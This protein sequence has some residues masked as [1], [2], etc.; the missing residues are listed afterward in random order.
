M[1][2]H[3]LVYCLLFQL[4]KAHEKRLLF[5]HP[6]EQIPA[7]SRHAALDGN[8]I[9]QLKNTS[10]ALDVYRTIAGS[11]APDELGKDSPNDRPKKGF[12]ARC[13][14]SDYYEKEAFSALQRATSVDCKQEI[15]DVVCSQKEGKLFTGKELPNYCTLRS[16]HILYYSGILLYIDLQLSCICT[17]KPVFKEHLNIPYYGSIWSLH[18]I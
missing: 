6:L 11:H 17:V 3:V 4:E 10:H 9:G 16:K 5:E 15:S 18:D 14:I 8:Q 12:S 1:H 7:G 13:Q 2:V